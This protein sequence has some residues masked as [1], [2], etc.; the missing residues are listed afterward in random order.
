MSQ[1]ALNALLYSWFV[2]G[3]HDW[4]IVSGILT[5]PLVVALFCEWLTRWKDKAVQRAL[6]AEYERRREAQVHAERVQKEK[7]DEFKR[8]LKALSALYELHEN[9]GE[10]SFAAWFNPGYQRF[11]GMLHIVEMMVDDDVVPTKQM[12]PYI[13][14]LLEQQQNLLS[15]FEQDKF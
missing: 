10:C 2:A 13:V 6:S 9:I 1:Q 4:P 5:T 12:W 14:S 3:L 11:R 7:Q 8:L 15:S